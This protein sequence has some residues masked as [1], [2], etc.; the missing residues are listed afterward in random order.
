MIKRH[1]QSSSLGY[2]KSNFIHKSWILL[3]FLYCLGLYS[4]LKVVLGVFG[5]EPDAVHSLMLWYGINEHGLGWVKDWL[6]TQDN[7]LFSLVPIHFVE[8]WLLGPKPALV[9]VTGW[10]IFVASTIVAGLTA[11][12]LKA[13]YSSYIVPVIL[14]FSGLYAHNSGLISYSTSHNITNLFGLLSIFLLLGWFKHKKHHV[15]I[16]ILLLNVAGGLSDPWMLP[17]YTLPTA[18]V[19]FLLILQPVSYQEKR[20]GFFLILAMATS[21]ILVKSLFFGLFDFLPQMH[22]AIGDW[23]TL[24]SNFIYLV[25]DLGRLFDIVP[26][27]TPDNLFYSTI[28]LTCIMAVY[29]GSIWLAVRNKPD[30]PLL[31]FIY[32]SLISTAGMSLA[33]LISSTAATE[34]SARFLLNIFY[35]IVISIA[36]SLER[37]WSTFS[38]LT[39]IFSV[40]IAALF[41]IAGFTST[42]HLFA[43][44]GFSVK[45]SEYQKLIEFL[46]K[47]ELYYGYGPYWGTAANAVTALSNSKIKLRPIQF[48]HTSGTPIFAKRP[49]TSKRW[50]ST[51]DFPPTQSTF[52]VIVTYDGE[53]CPVPNICSNGLISKYGEP[54]RHLQYKNYEI[55]VWEQP[56]IQDSSSVYIDIKINEEVFFNSSHPMPAWKGWSLSEPAGT[57]SDG[58]SSS[59][60]LVISD[61]PEQDILLLIKGQAFLADNHPYQE[62]SV[63][64]NNRH[65]ATLKYDRQSNDRVRKIQIPAELL[66]KHKGRL[67]IE[68][69]YKHPISPANLGLTAA[70]H[71]QLALSIASI[72]LQPIE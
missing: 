69:N 62:I 16:A 55:F 34:L 43:K 57:W 15:L 71:R 26:G 4:S 46:R 66:L 61:P 14:I 56:L 65:V 18:I 1:S 24:K 21:I 47:N 28:S 8:F 44:T 48:D 68:F 52:F 10:L 51:E 33:F 60:R 20:Y 40:S 29:I 11:H 49:E 50:Y 53:E 58:D 59:M 6:F 2:G 17:S 23:E 45:T 25:S 36:V 35:L 22:F 9:I 19:G 12:E 3:P 67:S 27:R 72:K 5:I 54:D 30:T 37:Y 32:F 42:T 39:K 31:I 13:K 63:H 70:D 64:L 41:V 7:W 38:T